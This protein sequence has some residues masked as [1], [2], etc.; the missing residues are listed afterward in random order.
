MAWW[1]L[2]DDDNEFF[3]LDT[4]TDY[5]FGNGGNDFLYGLGGDDWLDGGEGNDWLHGGS[6][7][8]T[9]IG[10]TGNDHYYVHDNDDT[11]VEYADEGIDSITAFLNYTLWDNVEN[12]Y[13]AG[14]ATQGLEIG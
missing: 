3:G 9:L 1:Y 12:L 8:D 6:G 14:S 2:N 7:A 13:L 5:I 11:I 10:R 4:A